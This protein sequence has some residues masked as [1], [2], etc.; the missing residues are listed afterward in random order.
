[1][2]GI[3]SI[4]NATQTSSSAGAAGQ[5]LFPNVDLHL[6]E[7]QRKQIRG[8]LNGADATKTTPTELRHSI[9]KLLTPAQRKIFGAYL[10]KHPFGHH[11]ADTGAGTSPNS[12]TPA[13]VGG[14]TGA[15]T[16]TSPN[17]GTPA[18]VGGG[19][20]AGTGTSPNSGTPATVGGGTDTGSGTSPNADGPSTAAQRVAID[21]VNQLQNQNTAATSTLAKTLQSAL[22]GAQNE[23]DA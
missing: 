4:V 21:F 17:S 20:G 16:G 19:T 6:S 23:A 22:L 15:G 5:S 2:S 12:G 7:D 8:I 10:E 14:G 13:T 18:T 11:K 1:M 3:Q 9:S